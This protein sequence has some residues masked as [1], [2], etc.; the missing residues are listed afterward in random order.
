M[1]MIG[2]P[3]RFPKGVSGNP[4]GRPKVVADVREATR[5]HCMSA[6]ETLARIAKDKTAPPAAQVAA[7]CAILDRGYGKPMQQTM[8]HKSPIEGL[9]EDELIALIEVLD[10]RDV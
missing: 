6:I 7:A 3:G 1:N 8:V 2:N 5:R 9:S 4:G 10:E